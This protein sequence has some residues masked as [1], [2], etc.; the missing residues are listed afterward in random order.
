MMHLLLAFTTLAV[1]H[2]VLE[3]PTLIGYEDIKEGTPPCGAFD[4]TSRAAVTEWP[5]AG[6][7][8]KI[9]ST[10][11][12]AQYTIQPTLL[13]DATAASGG[14]FNFT[15][16]V[17]FVTQSGRGGLRPL[18]VPGIAAWEGKDAVVQ[19]IQEATDEQLYQVCEARSSQ[20]IP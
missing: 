1:A 2:F 16:M 7:S 20:R 3:V 10:H 11:P 14:N 17:P 15:K 18:A 8:L 4:I 6:A 12:R 19:V 13:S 5:L 9:I